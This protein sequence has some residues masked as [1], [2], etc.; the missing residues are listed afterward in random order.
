VID[1]FFLKIFRKT[2]EKAMGIHSV[3][4]KQLS[5]KGMLSKI[6]SIFNK[7]PE[8]FKDTRGL[9]A[10]ISLTDCFNVL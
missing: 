6:R 9:K 1:C 8:P 7:I 4:K 10:E 5:A 3:E 2:G